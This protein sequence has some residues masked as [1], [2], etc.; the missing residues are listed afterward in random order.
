MRTPMD[1]ECISPPVL[2]LWSSS[3]FLQESLRGFTL[4]TFVTIIASFSE[5]QRLSRLSTTVKDV[6]VK[7]GILE[8]KCI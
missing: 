3:R 4:W 1:P 7:P 6:V 2:Q 8:Q 5:S